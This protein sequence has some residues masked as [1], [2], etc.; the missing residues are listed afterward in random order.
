MDPERMKRLKA[1]LKEIG[2]STEEDLRN[3]IRDLPAL[4]I[5]VMTQDVREGIK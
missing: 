1:A 4:N 3:A 5:S 2:I